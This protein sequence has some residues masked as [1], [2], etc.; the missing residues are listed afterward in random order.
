MLYIATPTSLLV[1]NHFAYYSNQLMAIFVKRGS[2][3]T[4][5]WTVLPSTHEERVHPHLPKSTHVKRKFL[6][7]TIHVKNNVRLHF[8]ETQ[9]PN[10]AKA[11][12][13]DRLQTPRTKFRCWFRSCFGVYLGSH[14]VVRRRKHGP[15]EGLDLTHVSLHRLEP[16]QEQLAEPS[17]RCPERGSTGV[18]KQNADC[19]QKHAIWHL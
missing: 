14:P 4:K 9:V 17:E 3:Y 19:S 11:Q 5:S 16:G 6:N 10:T 12:Y 18:K 7:F 1:S 15:N 13:L 8:K 2:G